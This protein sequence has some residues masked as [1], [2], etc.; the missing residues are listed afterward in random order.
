[1]ISYA[2]NVFYRTNILYILLLAWKNTKTP[3]HQLPELKNANV[4]TEVFIEFLSQ[5]HVT[6]NSPIQMG[7]NV[8]V[9]TT[10]T[11]TH[12]GKIYEP[13]CVALYLCCNVN[14]QPPPSLDT[15]CVIMF[16]HLTCSKIK[17]TTLVLAIP[18]MH[19]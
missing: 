2:K 10:T 18:Q 1:M 15:F 8:V 14:N 5:V 3:F 6:T 7:P 12:H 17:T 11:F 13:H 9:A 19:Q 4:T 16:D